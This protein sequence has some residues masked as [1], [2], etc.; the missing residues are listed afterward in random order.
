M[1]RGLV[2]HH[3]REMDP[4]YFGFEAREEL[5]RLGLWNRIG[6]ERT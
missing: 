3:G 6:P 1:L 5:I 4:D 2:I